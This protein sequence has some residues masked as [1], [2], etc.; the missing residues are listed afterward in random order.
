MDGEEKTKQDEFCWL[1]KLQLEG[2]FTRPKWRQTDLGDFTSVV[3]GVLDENEP[4]K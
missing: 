1:E 2:D 3:N 4:K